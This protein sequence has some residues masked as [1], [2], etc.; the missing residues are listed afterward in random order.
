MKKLKPDGEKAGLFGK[1][2]SS[3]VTQVGGS[4]VK[5]VVCWLVLLL[6][7]FFCLALMSWAAVYAGNWPAGWKWGVPIAL[8]VLALAIDQTTFSLH[9]FYRQRLA[10]AFSVRRAVLKD[11]SVGALPYDYRNEPTLLD[12]YAQRVKGFPQVIFAASAAISLRTAPRPAAPLCPSLSPPTTAAAPTRD[13]SVP[14]LCRRR[15][16][17]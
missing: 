1:G 14:T 13:G 11:G 16:P 15:P 10:G 6:V 4:W 17:H 7:A 9:P 3:L 12:P 5:A 2:G 8:I